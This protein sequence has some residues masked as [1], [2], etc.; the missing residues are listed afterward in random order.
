M[1][2]PVE[3]QIVVH[4]IEETAPSKSNNKTNPKAKSDAGNHGDKEGTG[5]P[6]PT[7]GLPSYKLLTEDG[8]KVGNLQSLP[9][10][11]GFNEYDG[12]SIEDL[13]E[14]GVLYKIN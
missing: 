11:E 14:Q 9:W 6:A 12:G 8:R 13:G 4:I 5:T 3:D 2:Q 10:P 7:H 1:P